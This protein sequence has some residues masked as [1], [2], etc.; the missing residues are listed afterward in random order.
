MDIKLFKEQFDQIL[1]NYV[2]KKITQATQLLGD[3]RLNSFVEYIHSFIFAG[4]KRIRPYCVRAMYIGFGG[5]QE[6]EMLEFA[7]VFELFHTFALIHDDIIDQADKRHNGATMHMFIADKIGHENFHIAEGQAM[8]IGDLLLAWVY[9]L[10][11]SHPRFSQ[12]LLEEAKQNVHSMIEEVILGQMIDV[13]MMTGGEVTPE[14]LEK[15]NTY[16]T[17]SYTFVRPLLTGA[18]LA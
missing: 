14:L 6:Q 4:G 3:K 17:A 9:E 11:N 7:M 12:Q 8:L 5:K 13:D 2:E 16:K 10:R 18:I 1:A 15:K